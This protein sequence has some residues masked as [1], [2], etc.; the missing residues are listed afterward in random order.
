MAGF[1]GMVLGDAYVN[2]MGE[3]AGLQ[4]SLA[5]AHA[6]VSGFATSAGTMLAR[7]AV[8]IP[9]AVGG[10]VVYSIKKFMEAEVVSNKLASAISMVGDDASAMMPKLTKLADAIAMKTKWDDEDVKSSMAS[11]AALGFN[12]KKIEEA[13]PAV[14]GLA[15]RLNMGLGGAMRLTVRASQGHTQML[16]RYGLQLDKNMTA[17]QKYQAVLKYG[18]AGIGIAES[19]VNTLSGAFGQMRKSISEVAESFGTGMMRSGKLTEAIKGITDW[20]WNL[21]L[22][23]DRLVEEGTFQKWMDSVVGSFR[24]AVNDM[25]LGFGIIISVIKG[26]SAATN[27]AF[28]SLGALGNAI[29]VTAKEHG[30][31][32]VEN[33]KKQNE[34]LGYYIAQLHAE[35][36]GK[37][38]VAPPLTPQK[39]EI[40]DKNLINEA[41]KTYLSGGLLPEK[42]ATDVFLDDLNKRLQDWQVK[43][44]EITSSIGLGGKRPAYPA[45]TPRGDGS[46]GLAEK[47][48]SSIISMAD[49]WKKMQEDAAKKRYDESMKKTAEDQLDAQR[50][51]VLNLKDIKKGVGSPR[52]INGTAAA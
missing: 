26:L 18:V 16:Q 44:R 12:T 20:I 13:M 29:A 48:S 30:G 15:A 31:S 33:L 22:D 49:V 46:G 38:W 34:E 45:G 10:A 9:F 2:I 5:Q 19:E 21:K 8:I 7:A 28:I 6:M 37:S 40:P 42:G 51:M 3:T 11:A 43:E 36:T 14:V 39:G 47:A 41:W 23:I 1:A 32:F 50:E 24:Y 52:P 25:T 35:M 17:E 27:E 4:R